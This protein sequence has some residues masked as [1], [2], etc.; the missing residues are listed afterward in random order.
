MKITNQQIMLE[1]NYYTNLIQTVN[2]YMLLI[3][4]KINF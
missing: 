2:I 3:S 1:R 4:F